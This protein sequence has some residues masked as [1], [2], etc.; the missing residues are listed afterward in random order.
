MHAFARVAV[1]S[2]QPQLKSTDDKTPTQNQPML[3]L[4]QQQQQNQPMI[5][6]QQQQHQNQPTIKLQQHKPTDDKTPSATKPPV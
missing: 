6:L 4:Q 3:K 5:K 1:E 2:S